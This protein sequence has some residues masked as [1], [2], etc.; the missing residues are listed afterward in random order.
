MG[1]FPTEALSVSL[2]RRP[3]E[4]QHAAGY[5]FPSC[6]AII[7][8]AGL[9]ERLLQAGCATSATAVRRSREARM[10][11][12]L[13]GLALLASAV[14]A[15]AQTPVARVDLKR[16]QRKARSGGPSPSP[17]PPDS[18]PGYARRSKTPFGAASSR[19]LRSRRRTSTWK[20]SEGAA[21]IFERSSGWNI[22][23]QAPGS[24][25]FVWPVRRR[26]WPPTR[27]SRRLALIA[28]WG[29]S[30]HGR[31]CDVNGGDQRSGSY[32]LTPRYSNPLAPVFY[33]NGPIMQLPVRRL[34]RVPL[35]L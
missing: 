6:V 12:V 21:G 35:P 25:S 3:N 9:F 15:Y 5:H 28:R 32:T 29:A 8:V 18:G 30:R 19:W 10:R 23:R 13:V 26:G 27:S 31:V 16:T 11:S 33:Q 1:R 2:T 24:V 34:P 20:A 7:T 4:T 22:S 14:T 17:A